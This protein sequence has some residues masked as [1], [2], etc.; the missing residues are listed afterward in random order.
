MYTYYLCNDGGYNIIELPILI[1]PGSEFHH[2]EFLSNYKVTKHKLNKADNLIIICEKIY[3]PMKIFTIKS[4]SGK[5]YTINAESK[6]HAIQKAIVKD[7][8][9]YNSN[10]Y[11]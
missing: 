6:F 7:D 2:D 3:W 11:K 4:P 1:F 8:F 10:Q 5:V 9:K